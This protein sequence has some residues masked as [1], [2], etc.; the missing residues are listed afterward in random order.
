VQS[1]LANLSDRSLRYLEAG[2][3]RALIFL[4]AFPLSA[5]QWLPQLHRV[6]PGWRFIAPDLRGFRGGGTAFEATGL[7]GATLDLHAADV[8]TLMTHL[9]IERAVV[10][11]LS[12]GGYI[13]FAILRRAPARVA[14]LVLAN[15]R[16]TSDTV[17]GL[18]ARDRLI[19]VANREGAAGVARDMLPKL[20]GDTTRHEQPDLVEAVRRLI[21]VNAGEGLV[22]AI[23]AMK[24]RP[25]S[26]P[27]LPA[28]ACRALIVAGEEDALIP[29]S[30][31]ESMRHDIPGAE[32]IVIPGVGHLSNLEAPQ[33]FNEALAAFLARVPAA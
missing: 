25:D 6:P 3:G 23:R 26:R 31:T 27:L 13:A 5:D 33:P 16:A 12:M 17:E 21:E 28:I 8:L 32:L 20:L 24:I 4:H 10:A 18:A 29:G 19:A 1:R 2:S 22:S 11:G 7:E 15:T 14:G 30:D 9:E